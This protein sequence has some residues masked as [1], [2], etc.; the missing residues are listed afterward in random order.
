MG[1]IDEVL[2]EKLFPA[3]FRGEEINADFGKS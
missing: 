2:I 1:P 3:L